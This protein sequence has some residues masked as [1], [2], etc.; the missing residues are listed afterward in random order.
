MQSFLGALAVRHF[1]FQLGRALVHAP[2]QIFA[3]VAQLGVANLN[4]SQHFVESVDQDADFVLRMFSRP[5]GIIPGAGNHFR[6]PGQLQD[7]IRD[8][9]LQAP[10]HRICSQGDD[11]DDQR[12]K[13]QIPNQELFVFDRVPFQKHGSHFLALEN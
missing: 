12:K 3:G 6:G 2:L 13:E 4:L 10:R 7:G 11:G 5:N 9:A 8:R 1:L